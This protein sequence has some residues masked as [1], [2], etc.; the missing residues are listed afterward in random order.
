MK[1][2]IF[3]LLIGLIVVI[4]LAALA[5]GLFLDR[6]LKT[7]IE[8]VGP[9]LTQTDIKLESVSLSLL[10]GAGKIKGLVV[11]NPKGFKTPSA[12][13]VGTVSLTLAP[14]TLLSDKIVVKSIIVEGPEI[15]F[16]TDLRANN[17]S[18]IVANLQAVTGG[19]GAETAKAQ[20]PAQPQEA[21]AGKTLEVDD[22]LITDGKVHV[23]VTALGGEATTLSLPAIHLQNL[24]KDANGITPAELAKRVLEEIA[25]AATQASSGTVADIQKGALYVTKELKGGDTNVAEKVSKGLGNLFKK[26]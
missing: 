26:N 15:T 2:L 22:F 25:N 17:L 8:T 20:Q 5:L 24:G 11:G 4:V 14:R 18:K 21:K 13:K 1:K 10:S 9:K 12:I 3:R 6:A 16:E 19:G 7:G 23:S